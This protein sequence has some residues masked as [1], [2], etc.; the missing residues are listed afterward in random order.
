MVSAITSLPCARSSRA[1]AVICTVAATWTRP[2]RSEKPGMIKPSV[3]TLAEA[4]DARAGLA[5]RCGVGGVA[6]A[7]V[8]GIKEGR[9]VDDGDAFFL[10]QRDD[11]AFVVGDLRAALRGLADAAMHRREDV[12][13]ALRLVAGDAR[14][15]VQ[16]VHHQ[17]AAILVNFRHRRDALL[18]T[19]QRLDRR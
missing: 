15:L 4:L 5:Q 18:R 16:H 10:Q 12:E 11:E 9:A 2:S 7:E 19:V 1:R 6:D 8:T 3:Q 14:R 17:V 13:R